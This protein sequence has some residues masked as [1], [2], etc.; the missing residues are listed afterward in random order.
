MQNIKISKS[1]PSFLIIFFISCNVYV[2]P[3]HHF[4]TGERLEITASSLSL[5]SFPVPILIPSASA[6]VRKDNFIFFAQGQVSGSE[7]A[8]RAG[9]G[10]G[11]I[12]SENK[13]YSGKTLT[14]LSAGLFFFRHRYT[15]E[16]GSRY[17]IDGMDLSLTANWTNTSDILDIFAGGRV[18]FIYPLKLRPFV[19]ITGEIGGALGYKSLKVFATTGL[20]LTPLILT[21]FQVKEYYPAEFVPSFLWA[22]IGIKLAL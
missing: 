1:Y 14:Y 17:F 13:D 12:L 3:A 15:L 10:V 8:L 21:I 22:R 6:T 5:L 19:D 9:G 18:L 4:Y 2:P 20:V 7:L 16:D 11:K